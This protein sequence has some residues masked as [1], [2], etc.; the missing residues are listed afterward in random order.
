MACG[1]A[2]EGE[3][4]KEKLVE[5]S[6]MSGSEMARNGKNGNGYQERKKRRSEGGTAGGVAKRNVMPQGVKK[7]FLPA[8]VLSLPVYCLSAAS[9][10]W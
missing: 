8:A 2:D 5:K 7:E 6:R 9:F 4:I 10:D 3:R 1:S